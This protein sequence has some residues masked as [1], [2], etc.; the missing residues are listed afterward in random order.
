MQPNT[1]SSSTG[2]LGPK[3]SLSVSNFQNFSSLPPTFQQAQQQQQQQQQQMP[4]KSSTTMSSQFS[5]I[6]SLNNSQS[7]A[8]PQVPV[9]GGKP[10]LYQQTPLNT[11][12]SFTTPNQ[13]S[14]GGLTSGSQSHQSSF[15][16]GILPDRSMASL[17]NSQSTQSI[18]S[19]PQQIST[20]KPPQLQPQQ[21]MPPVSNQQ[22]TF[23]FN[24]QLPTPP[25]PPPSQPQPQ[26]QP[27]QQ[28]T[29]QVNFNLQPKIH[30]V[31]PFLK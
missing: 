16:Q 23:S 31:S 18:S 22:T 3:S 27:Q 11:G 1:P 15:N 29:P 7:F 28:S 26:P 21:Q 4:L 19:Q 12:Q 5:S 24:P 13:L 30:A 8:S 6:N 17:T 2:D 10:Q 9:V 20:G 14:F 25:P